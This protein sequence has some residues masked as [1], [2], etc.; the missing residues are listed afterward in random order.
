MRIFFTNKLTVA[1]INANQ[2]TIFNKLKPF[3]KKTQ[4]ITYILSKLGLLMAEASD[5]FYRVHIK[6]VPIVKTLLGAWPI[7]IDQSEFIQEEE[8]FQVDP[9]AMTENIR[10][11]IYSLTPD[12]IVDCVLE[13]NN[14]ILY[15][16]YL[17]I[18]PF[19][20]SS[21]N[22]TDIIHT[23]AIKTDLLQFLELL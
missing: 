14:N 18:Q 4:H 1:N 8:W 23:P 16:T 5:H 12:S 11:E 20:S 22:I 15:N 9:N 3:H 6:D 10:R 19:S 17:Q 21:S 7:I 13:Y 2:D